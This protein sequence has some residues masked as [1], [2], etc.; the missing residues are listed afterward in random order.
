MKTPERL[1]GHALAAGGERAASLLQDDD[2][3]LVGELEGAARAGVEPQPA[4]A[5]L[6]RSAFAALLQQLDAERAWL[7]VEGIGQHM[8]SRKVERTVGGGVAAF[9]GGGRYRPIPVFLD[10]EDFAELP[11]HRAVVSICRHDLAHVPPP[12]AADLRLGHGR[13]LRLV[14]ELDVGEEIAV[15]LSR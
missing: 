6:A 13:P 2:G 4:R 11:R 12:P 14:L 15:S 8:F 9:K 10:V 5:E 3:L 7:S 1:T